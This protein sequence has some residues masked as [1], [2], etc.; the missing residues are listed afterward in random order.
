MVNGTSCW[1]LHFHQTQ[2]M[3]VLSLFIGIY[4]L[5]FFLMHVFFTCHNVD[6]MIPVTSGR[7]NPSTRISEIT[8]RWRVSSQTSIPFLTVSVR[9]PRWRRS[10]PKRRGGRRRC[11]VRMTST[12]C[13]LEWSW[14]TAEGEVLTRR[15]TPALFEI[16]H[17]K[18]QPTNLL[19]LWAWLKLVNS[20]KSWK[21]V[22][23]CLFYK[24]ICKPD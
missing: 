2:G 5:F 16:R 14:L 24:N 6:L 11:L 23:T 22:A 12:S 17:W 4:Y 21:S 18:F 1:P 20:L 3:K 7:T 10:C 13:W 19:N 15:L 8:N 9:R